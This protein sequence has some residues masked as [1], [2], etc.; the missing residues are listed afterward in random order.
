[1]ARASAGM[2]RRRWLVA[3]VLL[4]TVLSATLACGPGADPVPA[5]PL[6]GSVLWVDPESAAALAEQQRGATATRPLL[7]A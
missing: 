6:A 4:S 2:S 7:T 5:N 1:M 3:S